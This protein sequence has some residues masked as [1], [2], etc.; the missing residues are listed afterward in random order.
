[1]KNVT[2]EGR[3]YHW[4]EGGARSL[5]PCELDDP[6]CQTVDIRWESSEISLGGSALMNEDRLGYVDEETSKMFWESTLAAG[7]LIAAA[8]DLQDAAEEAINIADRWWEENTSACDCI[9]AMQLVLK[10]AIAKARGET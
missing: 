1:M 4:D 7:R 2:L 8:P 5:T 6:M 9:E 3:V 10:E